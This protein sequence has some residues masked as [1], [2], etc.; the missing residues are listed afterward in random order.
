MKLTARVKNG[1]VTHEMV[2]AI[3]LAS[4]QALVSQQTLDP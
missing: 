3:G 4:K 2:F 1:T